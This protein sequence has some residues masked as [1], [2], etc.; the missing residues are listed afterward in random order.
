MTEHTDPTSELVSAAKIQAA[1]VLFE[2]RL[3]SLT[4]K[5]GALLD[6]RAASMAMA[7]P[8]G[9]KSWSSLGGASFKLAQAEVF[10]ATARTL[11]TLEFEIG[12][13][14]EKIETHRQSL[15]RLPDWL[16]QAVSTGRLPPGVEPLP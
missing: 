10:D 2:K 16:V 15:N 3:V 12:E 6:V 13:L 11:A 4:E 9:K 14:E 5:R 7:L 8:S 1:L